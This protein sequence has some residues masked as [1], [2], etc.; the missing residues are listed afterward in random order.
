VWVRRHRQK[1]SRETPPLGPADSCARTADTGADHT[2]TATDTDT[3]TSF[4]TDHEK[5]GV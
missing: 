1:R 2:D 5:D 4:T 3:D